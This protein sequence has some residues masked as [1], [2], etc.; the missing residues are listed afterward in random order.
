MPILSGVYVAVPFICHDINYL[1]AKYCTRFQGHLIHLYARIA[2]LNRRFLQMHDFF[3]HAV[4]L[5][6]QPVI[7]S[8]SQ[9]RTVQILVLS[10]FIFIQ[11]NGKAGY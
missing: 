1:H 3:L 7:C 10:G 5:F 9:I 8:S 2:A 4:S 6:K 11:E